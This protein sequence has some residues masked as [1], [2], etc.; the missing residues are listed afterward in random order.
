MIR[1]YLRNIKREYKYVVAFLSV[2]FFTAPKSI[3]CDEDWFDGKIYVPATGYDSADQAAMSF[4]GELL[5]LIAGI[6]KCVGVIVV[7]FGFFLYLKGRYSES[8]SE[9]SKGTHAIAIGLA[10]CIMPQIFRALFS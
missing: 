1:K 10:M 2:T 6:L 5:T 9:E 4:A 7:V 8:S 3:W